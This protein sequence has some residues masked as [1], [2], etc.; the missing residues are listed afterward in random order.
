ML[1]GG[2]SQQR[3]HL[4]QRAD[5]LK[6]ALMLGDG[7]CHL[8]QALPENVFHLI[9]PALK[10]RDYAATRDASRSISFRISPSVITLRKSCWSRMPSHHW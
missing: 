9:Q 5:G 6:L 8:D 10:S 7:Q 1:E 3:V 2:G 4:G